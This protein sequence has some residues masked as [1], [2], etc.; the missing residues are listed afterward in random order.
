MTDL[1]PLPVNRYR[2]L[3]CS[4]VGEER[5][6]TTVRLAGW[7]AAKRDHG[8]LLFV[9]LR[10]AG[11]VVQL[12][13]HPDLPAVFERLSSLRVES[14]VTVTGPVIARDEKDHNP[15]IPTGT[16]EVRVEAVEVLSEADV[17]PFPV[18]RDTEVPEDMRLRYRYLDLRRGPVLDRLRQRS[19]LA[20]VVRSQLSGRG[21]PGRRTRLPRTEPALPRRVLCPPPG[22]PAVQAAAHG[23]RS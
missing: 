6:G 18:E 19:R 1:G 5:V 7:I 2:S 21:F 16:V 4:D 13:S 12:V 14:V 11:G 15:K 22:A 23:E 3:R 9:D 8:G 20:A 17:L 10:D